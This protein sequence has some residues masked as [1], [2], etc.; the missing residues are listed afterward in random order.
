[1]P[2]TWKKVKPTHMVAQAI[3]D[4]LAIL[5]EN[6]RSGFLFALTVSDMLYGGRSKEAIATELLK[7]LDVAWDNRHLAMSG[8][9]SRCE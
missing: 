7:A 4:A 9:A 6:D 3:K 2:S 5:P 8:V 1:M